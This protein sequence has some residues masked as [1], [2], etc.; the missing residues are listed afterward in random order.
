MK[1]K[2]N[3]Y[4]LLVS[5]VAIGATLALAIAVFHDLFRQQVMDDL[6]NYAHVLQSAWMEDK[7]LGMYDPSLDKLRVTVICEDGT[8]VYDSYADQAEM[9]NHRTRPEVE[10]AFQ[11]GEGEA[12][13][14][15]STIDK[16]TFYYA[17]KMENGAVL[18]AAK[19]ASSIWAV[20]IRALPVSI[21]IA[22]LLFFLCMLLAHV[23]TRRLIEPVEQMAENMDHPDGTVYRELVPFITM[24]RQQHADIL[25]AAKVRQDFTANVSHE[26]KTPLTAI[27]GYAELIETGMVKEEDSMRFAG[28][29]HQNANRLLT[30]INDIIRLSELDDASAEI[31]ME[32]LDLYEVARQSLDMLKLS[33]QKHEIILE[34]DGTSCFIEGNRGMIEEVICNLCDNG[35][36]YNNKGGKVMVSVWNKPEQV[37]LSV[38]DTGIGISPEH[39]ERIFER[40]YRVD[41]SRSKLT[42][43]TGLGLA[44]VKHIV[45]QHHAELRV[46]S[47]VGKGTKILI[48]FPRAHV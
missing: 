8:V 28:E 14:R 34:L 24:I 7:E 38:R 10:Q 39:Q 3:S 27:S 13:R 22:L 46:Q 47:E 6:K 18:R 21:G 15:S 4:F 41:K 16:D 11:E 37:V 36:R 33:A 45:A 25:K 19:E 40:F 44:I 31:P 23:L 48:Y 29:I 17:V 26:L 32:R 42:G 35:I 2:I 5:A 30:L 43:G 12:V 9:E 20:F 1:K